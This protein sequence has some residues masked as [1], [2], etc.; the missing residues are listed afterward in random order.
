M[1][2]NKKEKIKSKDI[3]VFNKNNNN[4]VNNNNNNKFFLIKS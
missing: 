2:E 4:N 1:K 3:K